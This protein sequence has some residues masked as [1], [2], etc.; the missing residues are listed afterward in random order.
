MNK[1]AKAPK[2]RV[3][4]TDGTVRCKYVFISRTENPHS[5]LEYIY[6]GKL[7][8]KIVILCV[9]KMNHIDEICLSL[10]RKNMTLSSCTLQGKADSVSFSLPPIQVIWI[11]GSS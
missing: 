1:P 5:L 4:S 10:K 9:K 6:D 8:P 2:H 7:M 11:G 3:L